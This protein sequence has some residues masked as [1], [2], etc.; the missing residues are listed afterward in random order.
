M[1]NLPIWVHWLSALSI[2]TI[3]IV[4]LLIAFS[5]WR[6][7][8]RKLDIDLFDKRYAVYLATNMFIGAITTKGKP[9]FDSIATF[10]VTTRSAKFLF[11]L[12]LVNYL[13]NLEKFALKVWTASR[14]SES[15][16]VDKR[17]EVYEEFDKNYAVL[18]KLF[19]EL[20]SHF[21]PYLTIYIKRFGKNKKTLRK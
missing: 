2:P 12:A 9:E 7:S 14:K 13:D 6:L 20:D 5:Q 4:G 18:D 19:V 11:D 10:L 21:D 16:A 15:L 17:Q 1:A 8:R 3:A